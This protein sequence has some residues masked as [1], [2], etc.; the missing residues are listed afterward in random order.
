[1]LKTWV[2]LLISHTEGN[3][4]LNVGYCRLQLIFSVSVPG[5]GDGTGS[6]QSLDM[7]IHTPDTHK[8][9]HHTHTHPHSYAQ[10]TY[11]T[12]SPPDTNTQPNLAPL[13]RQTKQTLLPI[14]GSAN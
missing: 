1:M 8:Q 13:L 7:C 12:H 10:Q 11:T 5:Q 4:W 6:D 14:I 2:C 3:L 9:A